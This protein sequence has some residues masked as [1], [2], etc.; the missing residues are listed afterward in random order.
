M[1][2]SY[3]A[4]LYHEGKSNLFHLEQDRYQVIRAYVVFLTILII[5]NL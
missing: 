3:Y 1:C 4:T 2:R 5:L